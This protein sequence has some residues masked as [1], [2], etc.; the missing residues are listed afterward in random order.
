MVLGKNADKLSG[1]I[2]HSDKKQ[3]IYV[4]LEKNADKLY[5]EPVSLYMPERL[6]PQGG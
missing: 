2:F 1:A 5:H 6:D 3:T 4:V